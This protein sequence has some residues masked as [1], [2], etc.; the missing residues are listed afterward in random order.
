MKR[1]ARLS[2]LAGTDVRVEAVRKETSP[3]CAPRRIDS[4]RAANVDE[5]ERMPLEY[6][7]S[8]QHGGHRR[9][10]DEPLHGAVPR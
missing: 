1:L 10:R 7:A 5:D 2:F 4:A 9:V 8:P 3:E 6:S